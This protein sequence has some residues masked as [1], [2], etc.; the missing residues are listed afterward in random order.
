MAWGAIGRG[1]DYGDVATRW[2]ALVDMATHSDRLAH[3]FLIDSLTFWAF[4]GWLVP[5]DM[6]VRCAASLP[7]ATLRVRSRAVAC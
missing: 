7:G 3:S 2:S 4:Q 5:D 6:Y 1:A